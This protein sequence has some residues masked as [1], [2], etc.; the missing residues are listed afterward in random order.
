MREFNST[1]YPLRMVSDLLTPLISI[2]KEAMEVFDKAL[3]LSDLLY[4]KIFK[5]DV[6][7]SLIKPEDEEDREKIID[8]LEVYNEHRNFLLQL[9]RNRHRKNLKY[10][11][12]L[13]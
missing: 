12:V 2:D 13:L 3:V 1:E 7:S 4:E 8:Q 10:L 9:K 6:F 11:P 5:E